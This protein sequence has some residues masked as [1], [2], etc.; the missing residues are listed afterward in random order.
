MVP[1]RIGILIPS[2]NTAMEADFQRLEAAR[3]VSVHT[4]RLYIPDGQM[5]PEILDM[6][7][8]QL[9]SR[10]SSLASAKLDI[11]VYGCT[12]GSFYK[13]AQWDKDVASQVTEMADVPCITTS[14]AVAQALRHVEARRLSIITPYPSWTNQKLGAY[15]TSE[16]F[17]V[18]NI[19]GN[20]QAAAGGHRAVN[21]QE[22]EEIFEFGA[23]HFKNGADALFCSCTAWRALEV[24]PR[25]ER[26][27]NV[28]VITSNQATIWAAFR[29][30]G[31][32]DL[33][34]KEWAVSQG[35]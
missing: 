35:A 24:Q 11:I 15:Y 5:S 27:L 28:P 33:L 20:A 6:M 21:D 3:H 25:L 30:V 10:I 26:R 32:A 23:Q 18:L 2:T 16:G 8:A 31:R 19:E 34:P 1:K 12:S 17:E 22:P 13:G 14:S 4:E 7:N 9:A 29:S